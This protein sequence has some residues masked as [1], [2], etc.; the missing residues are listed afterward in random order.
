MVEK[1]FLLH[2]KFSSQVILELT[3]GLLLDGTQLFSLNIRE[4]PLIIRIFSLFF[5]GNLDAKNASQDFLWLFMDD[6]VT[7]Y[8]ANRQMTCRTQEMS[9]GSRCSLV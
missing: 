6:L 5:G 7:Y 8:A 3:I 4:L 2:L 9:K 1:I